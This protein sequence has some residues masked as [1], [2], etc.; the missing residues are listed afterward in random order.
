MVTILASCG[1]SGGGAGATSGSSD[2]PQA[3]AGDVDPSTGAG[4][5]TTTPITPQAAARFL[6]QA[7]FG[8]N[9]ASVQHVIDLGYAAWIDEQLA[10]PASSHLAAWDAMTAAAQ[11]ANPNA[12]AGQ[13]GTIDAFWRVA[14]S[15]N[16]QLRQRV[17]FALSQIFVVS[18]Q[19]TLVGNDPR[20]VA[21][22][23]DLLA[24]KGLGRYRDL[25]EGVALHPMMGRYLSTLGNRKTDTRTGRVPDENFAREVMQLFSIGLVQLA[26]DGTPRTDGEGAPIATYGPADITGLARVFTGWSWA[27]PVAPTATNSTCYASGAV[28]VDG[29]SRQD[30]E[31]SIKPMINYPAMHETQEKRFLGTVV[32]AGT[33]G[34]ASLRIALDTLAG[35]PNVGPFIGRQLIQHLVTSNPSPAYV[36]D[37]AQVFTATGGD[38][39][40]V[41][42]AI[43]LHPEARS[44]SATGGRLREPVLRLAAFLRAFDARS[45]SGF[46]KIG[47]TDDPGSKLG[48]TPLRSPSVFNFYRPGYRPPGSEAASAGLV[49]P[50]FQ[51]AHETSAAGYVNYMRNAAFFGVGVNPGG[52]LNRPD[53]QPDY[54]AE[55][56]LADTPGPLVDLIDRKLMGGAMPQAVKTEIVNAIATIGIST[57]S[58]GYA[59]LARRQR[60][61]AAVMLTLASPEFQVQK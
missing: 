7:S 39:K 37:V 59:D 57:T 19:D 3:P 20:A 60:V 15:G 36:R 17:A 14:L 4:T 44:P 24:D 30:A 38:L 42:K 46:Y 5:E 41:V 52:T 45:D 6:A 58:Q 28:K 25:L 61:A 1:G 48:Q 8:A 49:A 32:P 26:P 53:V 12:W 33:D 11:V 23:L 51:I 22:Y 34:P 16:D 18:M 47:N 43:L 13:D 35:H 55:L 54:G 9:E 29:V 31:R 10:L 50:E 2:A 40:A 21:H 56:A 27:C